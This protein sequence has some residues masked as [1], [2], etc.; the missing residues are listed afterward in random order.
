M[1]LDAP[2]LSPQPLHLDQALNSVARRAIAAVS[3]AVF[4]FGIALGSSGGVLALALQELGYAA[5]G[6]GSIGTWLA[7]GGL[8]AAIPWTLASRSASSRRLLL[9]TLCGY[10]VTIA[11]LPLFPSYLALVAGRLI[12]GAWTVGVWI[13]SETILLARAPKRYAARLSSLYG[14]ALALGYVFGPSLGFSLWFFW[15]VKAPFLGASLFG[16]GA[17]AIIAI[18]L[19]REQNGSEED[20]TSSAPIPPSV[21]TALTALVKQLFMPELAMFA[22]GYLKAGLLLF[23]PLYL[24]QERA[25]A[26]AAVPVVLT[27]YAAGILVLGNAMAFCGDRFGHRRLLCLLALAGALALAIC[28]MARTL[29]AV[30]AGGFLLGGTAASVF[31]ICLAILRAETQQVDFPRATALSNA[32]YAAGTLAGPPLTGWLYIHFGGSGLLGH[33]AG[34]WVIVGLSGAVWNMKANDK[35]TKNNG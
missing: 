19:P 16:L 23:L 8:L 24:V 28:L 26:M 35:P 25:F 12:E 17:A 15:G 14:S 32:F 2:L 1:A 31:P 9:T 29:A 11:L 13:A 30:C 5:A 6:I 3:L 10:G 21:P 18:G 4:F 27:W 7:A 20:A 33:L 22:S 34:L